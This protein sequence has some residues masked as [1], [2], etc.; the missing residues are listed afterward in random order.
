MRTLRR[1]RFAM[2]ALAIAAPLGM[3]PIATHAAEGPAV[4]G[5][6]LVEAK[7]AVIDIRSCGERLWGAVVWLKEPRPNGSVRLD[8]NN[9]DPAQRAHP[10]CG[11]KLLYDFKAAGP[12]EWE[13]GHIYSADEGATYSAKMSLVDSNTLKVR[14]FIGISL[15][16]KSQ[17]WTRAAAETPRCAT[18]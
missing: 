3:Q 15:F 4:A 6:W 18:S 16:G 2:T 8:D 7:D 13:D 12:N 9:P 1:H 5:L 10:V 11:L 17:V 14:G